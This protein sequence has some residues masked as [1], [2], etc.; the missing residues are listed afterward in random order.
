MGCNFRCLHELLKVLRGMTNMEEP[1]SSS[2]SIDVPSTLTFIMIGGLVLFSHLKMC[3]RGIFMLS[4]SSS[5]TSSFRQCVVLA[6][7]VGVLSGWDL[8]MHMF[9]MCPRLLHERQTA[10]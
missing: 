6:F 7:D 2:M 10:L 3:R 8:D 4:P 9:E 1:V 5:R